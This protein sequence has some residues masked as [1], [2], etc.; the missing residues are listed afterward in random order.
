MATTASGDDAIKEYSADDND[1]L[2]EEDWLSWRCAGKTELTTL[3][4]RVCEPLCA[5]G[6]KLSSSLQ[7]SLVSG[8]TSIGGFSQTASLSVPSCQPINS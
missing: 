7:C 1:Y 8:T 2:T 5:D 6:Y 4:N 3:S